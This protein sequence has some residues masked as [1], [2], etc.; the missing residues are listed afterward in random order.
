[1][2]L[3]RLIARKGRP[4]KTITLMI[5]TTFVGASHWLRK[6]MCNE[7]FNQFL[8]KNKIT[9]QF[10][11]SST[12]WWGGQFEMMVGLVKNPLNK[13]IGCGSY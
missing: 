10:N 6:A 7:K 11:L 9:K 8:A 4:K 13:T 1:M 12:P 3:K 2:S 5:G